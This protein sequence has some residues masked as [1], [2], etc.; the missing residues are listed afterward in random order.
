MSFSQF[1][2]ERFCKLA[3][4]LPSDEIENGDLLCLPDLPGGKRW[5]MIVGDK[6]LGF[7]SAETAAMYLNRMAPRE[8]RPWEVRDIRDL[9]RG[10]LSKSA[11][12]SLCQQLSCDE[13]AMGSM[14]RFKIARTFF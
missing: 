14:K 6:A 12:K 13:I 2:D 7:L 3:K 5:A 9:S 8:N 11:I 4:N 1:L 10:R